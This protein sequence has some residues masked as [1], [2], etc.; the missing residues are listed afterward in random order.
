MMRLKQNMFKTK[1]RDLLT[2]LGVSR[3]FQL[4]IYIV[5]HEESESCRKTFKISIS[6]CNFLLFSRSGG[7]F[8]FISLFPFEGRG[9]SSY[10]QKTIF[11]ASHCGPP[12]PGPRP[13][14]P[15]I[16]LGPPWFPSAPY[17]PRPTIQKDEHWERYTLKS[18]QSLKFGRMLKKSNLL[19][20]RGSTM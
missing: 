20:G 2:K 4:A 16:P 3:R 6:I 12:S 13:P 5:F 14:I 7:Y 10:V 18:Q 19:R 15:P 8:Y 17:F 1:F 11:T 9:I